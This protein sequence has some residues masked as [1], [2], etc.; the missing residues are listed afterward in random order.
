MMDEY[1]DQAKALAGGQSLTPMMNFRLVKPSV[2][3][4]LNRIDELG[5]VRE[6]GGG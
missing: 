1:G 6:Q 4:D 3:V 2:L 5:Y